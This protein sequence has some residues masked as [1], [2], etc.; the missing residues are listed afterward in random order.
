MIDRGNIGSYDHLP[1][2]FYGTR[3]E[4]ISAEVLQPMDLVRIWGIAKALAEGC[5]CR[6]SGYRGTK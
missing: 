3:L 5:R 1:R 6:I 4:G 2:G